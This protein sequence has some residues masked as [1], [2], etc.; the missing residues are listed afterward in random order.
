MRRQFRIK[1]LGAFVVGMLILSSPAWGEQ[2]R[3]V[4]QLMAEL[5][6]KQIELDRKSRDLE[7]RERTVLELESQVEARLEELETLRATIE[8]RIAA[9]HEKIGDRVGRLAKVYAAMK[10]GRAAP[11]VES[12]D[13]G[14]AAEV[15]NKM[16]Q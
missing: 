13:V 7:E 8:R 5:R 12:L 10:P 3:G 11:L 6:S 2:G 9:F 1:C 16:K 4:E 14:L 15:L